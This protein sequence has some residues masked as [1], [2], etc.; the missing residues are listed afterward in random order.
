MVDSSYRLVRQ[1]MR[2]RRDFL[3]GFGCVVVTTSIALT[4]PWVLRYAIDD[5]QGALTP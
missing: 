5:L 3:L 4:G 1:L 2:Y